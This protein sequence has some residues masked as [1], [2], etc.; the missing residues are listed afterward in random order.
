MGLPF[1]RAFDGSLLA[2][3]VV[4][5]A[6][7]DSDSVST[8]IPPNGA[9]DV[10]PRTVV[11]V[12]ISDI[13]TEADTDNT[14]PENITVVGDLS[15]RPY[16]GTITLA[17]WDND[18]FPGQLTSEFPAQPALPDD[19]AVVPPEPEP[20]DTLVF[21]PTDGAFKN[22]ELITVIVS[23]DITSRGNPIDKSIRFSFR[24]SATG[25]VDEPLF[26]SAS[27]PSTGSV[28]VGLRPRV[29][30]SF[31]RAVA[32]FAEGFVLRG[33]Q[34]GVHSDIDLSIVRRESPSAVLQVASRL[35]IDDALLP[36]ENVSVTLSST[37]REAGAAEGAVR[38]DPYHLRFRTEP[39]AVGGDW[40]GER[41]AE[42]I[43]PAVDAIAANWLP[44]SDGVEVALVTEDRIH[45]YSQAS[46]GN[47]VFNS[48]EIVR[49]RA[50]GDALR[51]VGATPYDLDADGSLDIVI[52]LSASD[53]TRVQYY[54][55]VASSGAIRE[56]GSVEFAAGDAQAMTTVDLDAD[57]F[58]ELLVSHPEA[59]F[60]SGPDLGV[61]LGEGVDLGLEQT[62]RTLTVLVRQL[63]APDLSGGIDLDNLEPA[64]GFVVSEAIFPNFP[65]ARRLEN[66]DFDLNGKI[67]LAVETD[68]GVAIY[69]NVGNASSPF[70]V[71]RVRELPVPS[72]NR[73]WALGDLDNDGDEDLLYWDGEGLRQH[74]NE[75]RPGGSSGFLGSD[76]T[77][78]V[79]SLSVA[80]AAPSALR[81]LD[82]SG[83]NLNDIV[84]VGGEI[85]RLLVGEGEGLFDNRP[86]LDAEEPI[87]QL[88]AVDLDGDSGLDAVV[89][90]RSA[91]RAALSTGVTQ[92]TIPLPSSF[93]IAS[94]LSG[95]REEDG[96]LQVVIRGDIRE[97]WVGYGI[98]LDY[99]ESILEYRGFARPEDFPE[100]VSNYDLCPDV[101]FAGCAGNASAVMSY[102]QAT[103]TVAAD[104]ILLGTFLFALPD[105]VD[106]A[107]TTTIELAGFQ[108]SEGQERTNFVLI[109]D[110]AAQVRDSVDVGAGT[111]TL[112]LNP[113][114][115]AEIVA[116]CEVISRDGD[117]LRGQISWELPTDATFSSFEIL[118]G[119][120]PESMLPSSARSYSFSTELVG[121]IEISVVG[122]GPDRE[123]PAVATCSVIGIRAPE[124][125]CE[126][127][128]QGGIR[129]EW[130]LVHDVDRFSIY[131]N[132][133]FL[134]AVGSTT[135]EFVDDEPPLGPVIYEVAGMIGT[136][137]GPRGA[138]DAVG[139][140]P[141]TLPPRVTRVRLLPR[142]GE[143][144][145]EIE[146]RWVNAQAYDEIELS[147]E[148]VDENRSVLQVVLSGTDT[149][150][151]FSGNEG[152][153]G[154]VPPGSYSF[155]IAGVFENQTS[156]SE[157]SPVVD[158][159]VPELDTDVRCDVDASGNVVVGW[160]SVW[161]GYSGLTVVVE[162]NEINVQSIPV[163]LEETSLVVADLAPV[164][165]Y[166]FS[167]VAQYNEPLPVDLLP[168]PDSLTAACELSFEPRIFVDDVIGGVG[169]N[170][171]EIPV[172][173]EV[174]GP[175]SGF[176]FTLQLPDFLTLNELTGL[177]VSAPG[178][179]ASLDVEPGAAGTRNAAV[180]VDGINSLPPIAEDGTAARV[181]Q[182]ATLIVS[183]PLNFSLSEESALELPG[184]AFLTF[185]ERGEEEVSTEGGTLTL[186]RRFMT[187][188]TVDI[189]A[190]S[191][192]EVSL[193]ARATF[194]ALAPD[195][196]M[197]GFTIHL[198]WNPDHAEL[199]PVTKE[200]QEP[201][202]VGDRGT[203]FFPTEEVI[204]TARRTGEVAVPWL[205]L[206][207]TD[208][209]NLQPLTPGDDMIL[210]V[211]RFRSKLTVDSGIPF[212]P[213]DYLIGNDVMNPTVLI[214]EVKVP[215]EVDLQ[216][217][218]GGGIRL[219][220]EET[221]LRLDALTPD[222]G[223]LLGGHSAV[224]SGGGFTTS[225]ELSVEFVLPDATAVRVT[226]L[227]VVSDNA[228]QLETPDS[229]LRSAD[230][231]PVLANVRVTS[232][233]ASAEL[234]DAYRYVVPSLERTD[235]PRGFARGGQL[236]VL[237]G[238]GFAPRGVTE[239]R[240]DA[241]GLDNPV[242]AQVTEISGDG[243]EIR[244]LTPNLVGFEDSIATII[245]E[246]PG[247]ATVELEAAYEILPDSG[248]GDELRVDRLEPESGTICGG[249]IV[250][251]EGDN[252]LPG[253]QVFFGDLAASGVSVES[254]TAATAT[255]PVVPEGTGAVD[256][257][258][259]NDDDD[260]VTL[261][262]GFTYTHPAPPFIRGDVNEDGE[263]A[264]TDAVILSDLIFGISI[265]HPANDDAG[266]ANDDGFVDAGDVNT[267]LGV[268]F[269]EF[270]RLN[271]PWDEPGLDPTPDGL[272]SCR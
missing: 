105:N 163:S 61:D 231:P 152:D 16:E 25:G 21:Q 32:P 175:V 132:G 62:P 145:N 206:D 125:S 96:L 192:E 248:G 76:D 134:E 176:R 100:G 141:E 48:A 77:V 43:E 57:G 81:V 170:A 60:A 14:N 244:L 181:R 101:E 5:A 140:A 99:D 167:L 44:D 146:L 122:N 35:A 27:D 150:F 113:P 1:R 51:V 178:G 8:T 266:D 161:P 173:A 215:G 246:V 259:V 127:D 34:S 261:D 79:T 232:S 85:V 136:V 107:Q 224:L 37:V 7:N 183:A 33:E 214:P 56:R 143:R 123:G 247:V 75:L 230:L 185:P 182:L 87:E 12:R 36:G 29:A 129:I 41:L 142:S 73:V 13:F 168:A 4:L 53:V 211:F 20:A 255:A 137:L 69:Q 90:S 193:A 195:Y 112:E 147:L 209:D 238:A 46:S 207:F 212:I 204:A 218:I 17:N 241:P 83:D 222:E 63:I 130:T 92:P 30:V 52:L 180:V 59:T 98:A 120:E 188:D 103:E 202:V 24:V 3:L 203:F 80:V 49:S 138:C 198:K 144:E 271:D 174:V 233:Q 114:P 119:G 95:V 10:D 106:E 171:L 58:P 191:G 26:V 109:I 264:I 160:E 40:I 252:F 15:A 226:E 133:A 197:L 194:N 158:V 156:A 177:R 45:L 166:T 2:A 251:L 91:L 88:V 124:V 239:V 234:V 70:S 102:V 240:F 172:F 269:E 116:E 54:E 201:S 31:N 257:R 164:G 184:G 210:M 153:A 117:L 272:T 86:V 111:F 118:V 126:D 149:E 263:V 242:D 223:S 229:L 190:G 65:T 157:L 131:R 265:S 82:V 165:V 260:A 28:A 258:V 221:P 243:R 151:V 250:R 154:G 39:G 205:A 179:N 66:A 50:E 108:E 128:G 23:H 89:F 11:A 84:H 249:S 68:A 38:L 236:M 217:V 199:L 268:L 228:L 225:G 256:V 196:Q 72:S 208:P 186:Y 71:R 135:R 74:V 67:D 115:P 245:V 97:R 213:V 254:R 189:P 121:D 9:T 93:E 235:L 169:S 220:T 237:R 22:G 216:G 6:C 155:T 148:R 55:V 267:I 200:D 270:D 110:G 159:P 19:G 253:L 64:P 187:L 94:D 78:P 139:T 162:R 18:V 104:D 262:D 47:W 42:K 219:V 227:S